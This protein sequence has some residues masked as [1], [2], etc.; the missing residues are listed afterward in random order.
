MFELFIDNL[1]TNLQNPLPGV[2][3]QFEMAHVKREQVLE[4]S[5]EAETY[6][7]SAVLI[8]LYPNEQQQTSVLLIE[9]MT[10]DG[11]HSGQ[12]ALPG[13]KV[14]PSDENLQATA[15]REFFEETGSDLIPII[16]GQLTPIYIPVSK[17]MVQPFVSYVTQK[18]NFSAS[19]YEV[20]ALIEWEITQLLNPDIVKETTI[21][22]TPGLILKTPY[23]D[24]Q[25][26]VLWGATAMMLNE[27]KWV[28]R[29]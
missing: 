27:L 16:I 18:P 15:L 13:G 25:G 2:Q 21:E 6:R 12:I 11:H 9:R 26:K 24:V 23:F 14:E 20:N 8:L 28:L 17:F 5:S 10:Y 29:Q 1:K 22:P 3:A 4:Q 19:A 7:P